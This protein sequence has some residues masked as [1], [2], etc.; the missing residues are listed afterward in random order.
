[1]NKL[2]EKMKTKLANLNSLLQSL[3]SIKS[4]MEKRKNDFDSKYTIEEF[5]EYCDFSY[6]YFRDV[7]N[8]NNVQL[9]AGCYELSLKEEEHERKI[10]EIREELAQFFEKKQI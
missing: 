2:S 7:T 5:K 8:D 9:F 6:H 4:V 1:M 3:S 10:K